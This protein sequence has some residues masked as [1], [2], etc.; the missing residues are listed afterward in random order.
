MSAKASFSSPS[1]SKIFMLTTIR[2]SKAHR[3]PSSCLHLP[4][5]TKYNHNLQAHTYRSEQQ[6]RMECSPSRSQIQTSMQVFHHLPSGTAF[7]PQDHKARNTQHATRNT[8]HATRNTGCLKSQH[9]HSLTI[10]FTCHKHKHKKT[11]FQRNSKKERRVYATHPRL[12]H[13]VTH[14]SQFLLNTSTSSA[15]HP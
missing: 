12:N 15:R 14:A 3:R 11:R 13:H 6:P 1:I 4:V 8:Q 7:R 5:S 2:L 9:A 10:L